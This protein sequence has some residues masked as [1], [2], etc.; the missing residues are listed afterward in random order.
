ME[1]R[2]SERLE[3]GNMTFVPTR[4]HDRGIGIA[5]A[6][7]LSLELLICI[8]LGKSNTALDDE[9]VNTLICHY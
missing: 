1:R 3:R 4:M 5:D 6:E 9:I 2:K 8:L 7:S